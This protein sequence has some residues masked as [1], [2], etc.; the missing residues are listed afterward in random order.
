MGHRLIRW[1]GDPSPWAD[2]AIA[3]ALAQEQ[4]PV[5]LA[6]K[7]AFF[8]KWQ[9]QIAVGSRT[10]GFESG[11]SQAYQFGP[12]QFLVWM[13]DG[14]WAHLSSNRWER[15]QFIDVTDSPYTVERPRMTKEQW[16]ILLDD[17]SRL[18]PGRS[19]GSRLSA[20]QL[21]KDRKRREELQFSAERAERLYE[22][23]LRLARR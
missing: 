9:R 22:G 13:T 21:A 15:W 16:M 3:K 1:L 7:L 19:A 2:P 8:N 17:F 5:P 14:D 23:R 10:I 11:M 12:Q 20:Q 18:G 4:I 6:E